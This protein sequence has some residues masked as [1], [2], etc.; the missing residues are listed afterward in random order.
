[1]ATAA[2]C[3]SAYAVK[4]ERAKKHLVLVNNPQAHNMVNQTN[5]GL[6]PD[7]RLMQAYIEGESAAFDEL[8]RRHAQ[9]VY[10]FIKRRVG[11]GEKSH[12][13]IQEVFLRLHR[14][15]SG[16]DAS[17]PFLPWLF[18]ITRNVVVDQVRS[19]AR[20]QEDLLEDTNQD[21]QDT[22][23]FAASNLL[24]RSDELQARCAELTEPQRKVL[25]LR[26]ADDLAFEEI[27]SRLGISPCAGRQLFSRTVRKLR[28][29]L[30]RKGE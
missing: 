6:E 27:A 7:E 21:P 8:Y 13:T 5:F 14:S 28:G 23:E 26:L 16:Y 12:D 24:R 25:S 3:F 15:R 19:A 17:L 9:K 22:N 10:A 4:S 18:T 20:N 1:V 11:N 2:C 30:G 29:L